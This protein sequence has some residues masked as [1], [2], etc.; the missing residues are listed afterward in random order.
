[1]FE[2]SFDKKIDG[3][4]VSV[5]TVTVNGAAH[6]FSLSLAIKTDDKA[7]PMPEYVNLATVSEARF[8]PI[9]ARITQEM[10]TLRSAWGEHKITSRG[11]LTFF[12]NVIGM[13][14]EIPPEPR[15]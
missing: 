13:P 6:R 14:E 1:M 7:E 9:A 8:E 4:E 5:N 12:L 15:A 10:N 3:F 2:G 11:M